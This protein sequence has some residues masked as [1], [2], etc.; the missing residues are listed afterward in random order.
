MPLRK[1]TTGSRKV[2]KIKGGEQIQLVGEGTFG[3]VYNDRFPCKEESDDHTIDKEIERV[4]YKGK[5]MVAK[6]FRQEGD[7][8]EEKESIHNLKKKGVDPN[9]SFTVPFFGECEPK[10]PENQLKLCEMEITDQRKQR[11]FIF[12]YGGRPFKV[13]NFNYNNYS[14]ILQ[15][16]ASALPAL[17]HG[18]KMLW[19]KKLCHNDLHRGNLL[20]DTSTRTSTN[21]SRF[22]VIDFGKLTNHTSIK[23]HHRPWYSPQTTLAKQMVRNYLAPKN[24]LSDP[25]KLID[26]FCENTP[27]RIY[28]DLKSRAL[29]SKQSSDEFPAI[30]KHY[31]KSGIN[32]M[33]EVVRVIHGDLCTELKNLRTMV[34]NHR[35]E[36]LL[37]AVYAKYAEKQDTYAL[38]MTLYSFLIDLRAPNDISQI[39]LYEALITVA[40]QMCHPNY[41]SRLRPNQLV[42]S[43]RRNL[44]LKPYVDEWIS[45][46]KPKRELERARIIK[47]TTKKQ[48]ARNT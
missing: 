48:K 2:R 4:S 35:Y 36:L 19:D 47:N 14:D 29:S 44:T 11:Q 27:E 24:N 13:Q 20:F 3:C 22:N 31:Q 33:K 16:I 8:T 30:A 12:G 26:S 34:H 21:M 1:K 41:R 7:I 6:I 5:R 18:L 40:L 25:T 46:S 17:L 32:F 37:F 15:R 10:I 23:V 43:M 42:E 45:K 38:G 39:A 9:F 28:F